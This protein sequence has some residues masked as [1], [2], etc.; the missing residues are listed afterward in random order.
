MKTKEII[1]AFAK[2]LRTTKNKSNLAKEVNCIE[3]YEEDA[4]GAV[5][6]NIV[7]VQELSTED[8]KAIKNWFADDVTIYRNINGGAI[9][10]EVDSDLFEAGLYDIVC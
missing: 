2:K 5:Y 1:D 3:V 9:A 10:I 7:T 6:P 8:F 4:D